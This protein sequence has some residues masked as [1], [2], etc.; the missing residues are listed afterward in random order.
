MKTTED[1]LHWLV[2]NIPGTSRGLPEGVGPGNM[3]DGTMQVQGRGG[4]A[5]YRGPGAPA[6]GPDHHYTLELFALDA[7]LD[8]PVTA[9]RADV[10]AAVSG[11]IL[12]K[13]VLVGRFKRPAAPAAAP[14]AK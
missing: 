10:M 7:K 3:V 2:W 14:A 5:Q 1:I 13:G 6:V 4:V 11:H 8:L 12:G 9:T